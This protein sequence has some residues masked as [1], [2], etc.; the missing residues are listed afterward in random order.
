MHSSERSD[1]T[2]RERLLV[3]E[4]DAH[5]AQG[6]T[7]SRAGPGRWLNIIFVFILAVLSC[8]VGVF[9]GQ[10][11]GDSDEACTRR[12]T[13][14]SPVISNVGL[15]Y[16]SERFNG[17]LLKE[18]IFRQDASPEVDAAWASIGANYRA[19]RVPAEEAEKSGLAADQVKISEKYGGGYPAN[20]EG[21]HHLHCLNLLRQSL[22][23]NYDYYHDLGTGAFSNNEFIVRRHVTHCLDILRQQLMCSVDVGVLGQVWVHPDHPEP[24]VDFNTEHKCRN[25][26]QIREWAQQNQ[27]PETVPS[28]FLEPPKI[29]DRV[30]EAIP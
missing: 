13:Q 1:S 27:L 7:N 19:I 14:H 8:L 20:V 5:W 2:D 9:I 11:R 10:N 25:F 30:Y 26:D 3:D 22:Y 6:K 28:D 4:E 21:L 16:H 29:G 12:V 23:Y 15:N 18:N 17:S 24:F